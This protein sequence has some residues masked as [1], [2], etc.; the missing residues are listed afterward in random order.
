MVGSP[1]GGNSRSRSIQGNCYNRWRGH[2]AGRRSGRA[3][4]RGRASSL[5]RETES[6][7]GPRCY[8]RIVYCL[9]NTTLRLHPDVFE[10]Y[11]AWMS[12]RGL[13]R[14]TPQRGH[15]EAAAAA[16]DDSDDEGGGGLGRTYRID[17]GLRDLT[18]QDYNEHTSHFYTSGPRG[19]DE[20]YERSTRRESLPSRLPVTRSRKGCV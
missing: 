9:V 8:P 18:P 20:Q 6:R 10:R 7:H 3:R 17:L 5:L 15:G 11:A 4:N 2:G 19:G 14:V 12:R 1:R 16:S 13:R